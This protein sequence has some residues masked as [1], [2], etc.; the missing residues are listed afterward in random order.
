MDIPGM[1]TWTARESVWL[2]ILVLVDVVL[3]DVMVRVR[4]APNRLGARSRQ[5]GGIY[6]ERLSMRAAVGPCR[7]VTWRRPGGG[8]PRGS[9]ASPIKRAWPR[10]ST[11]ASGRPAILH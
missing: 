6:Y 11:Q 10:R 5:R 1:R 9:H 3:V 8:F 7:T 4:K 2:L